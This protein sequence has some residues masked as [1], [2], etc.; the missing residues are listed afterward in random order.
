[1]YPVSAAYKTAIGQNVRDVRIT[2]TITLK[3]NSVIN[4]TD[5]DIVQGSLYITEQCVAGEDIEVGNVYASEMGLSLRMPLENPYSL[6]GARIIIN[7]GIN[8]ET[9][10]DKPPIWEYVPLGYFYV[11]EIQRKANNVNLT[12]LDGM[13]LFDIPV[14]DPGSSSPRNFVVYACEQAGVPLGTSVFEIDT[15]ANATLLFAAPDASKIKTCR[16]LLMW[17]CQIMGAFARMNRQGELEIVP[18]KARPSV[19]TISKAERFNSDVSDFA[20][21]ITKVSMQ[22]G[23]TVYSRG[24]DGMTMVLDENPFM[25]GLSESQINAVLDNLLAQITTAVYVPFNSNFIGDPALQPGDFVTLADT[26]VLGGGDV[27]SIITHSTWRY[28]GP[29]NLKAAGKHGLVRGVQNQQM[30]AVSSI[31]AIARAAQDL[32]L[33]ANQSTQLI[34]DA[35][36]G[37]VLIRQNPDETNEILIMDNPDPDQAVKIWR[38][39]MGG[40]GYSDNCVGADNPDREYE[41]AMTMDGAINANFIKTGQLDA[42]VVRIGPETTFAPGYD[43]TQ[44][45]PS[46]SATMGVDA[47]CL[48]LWH[49]DGSLNSHKGVAAIGD[50][51]FD[52]G[53]FGQAVKVTTPI[54]GDISTGKES[55]MS[56]SSMYSSS[57]SPDNLVDGSIVFGPGTAFASA[58]GA[59]F[60]QWHQIDLGGVFSINKVR[61]INNRQALNLPKDYTI[62]ISETGAFAGEQTVVATVTGNTTYSTWVEHTFNPTKGRYVRMTVSAV[63]SGT[64]YE[65]AEWQ[66][67]G[68]RLG[69]LKAPTTGLSAS[70]G[71]ISFR[72][73][74]LAESANGSVLIDLP[75]NVGNQGMLCGIADDGNLFIE[76]AKLQFSE[77]ETSQADFNTGTLSD[78]QA[79][80]AGN[81][82]LARDGQDFTY[83]ETS[84]ADF[85][86]GTLSD[87]VATSAGDLEIKKEEIDSYTKLLLHMD[88]SD[89]GT[90][91]TDECGKTVTRY[92]AVTK[93]G[94]KKF[95]TA[96]GY[97][98]GGESTRLEI[99]G[100]EAIGTGDFTVECWVNM[101]VG[102]K[103]NSVIE[104]NG[105]PSMRINTDNKVTAPMT[106]ALIHP[107]VLSTGTWYHLALVRYNGNTKLYVNGVGGTAIEDSRNYTATS[108][109]IGEVWDSTA[110]FNFNGYIDELRIS[111][112]IARWTSDFT[113]PSAPYGDGYKT[114]G[115]RIKEIDLSGANPAGGTKIEWSSTTP[116]G[117]SIKVE[118]ALS[119][120]G[121]NTYGPWL[122]AINGGSIPGIASDTDLSNAK[123][124]I[125]QTLSTTDASVTPKLHSLSLNIYAPYKSSGYRYKEYD[126]SAVGSVGSSKISWTEN[127][128]AN[129][130]LTVK[131]AVSTDGGSTYGSWQACTSGQ[132]IPG[133]T[134]GMDIS[135]ARLKVQEDLGTSDGTVTP[136]LQS[137]TIEVGSDVQRA[138]GPN[139][140]TLTAWDSISLAWKP[141]RLSLVVND[142]EACYIENPGLP[143]AFGSHVFI[144]TDR[145]GA[146]A[147]N[148]L[149]DE[150]RIDKVYREVNTR[151]GWHKTGVPFYTSEDM[152]QWPGYLRAETDGLKVYDSSDALRVLV[153]SWLKDAVRKYGIKII[154]GEIYST[155]IKTGTEGSKTYI[156]MEP[157]NKICTYKEINGVAV[158]QLELTDDYLRFWHNGDIIGWT[159]TSNEPTGLELALLGAAGTNLRLGGNKVFINGPSTFFGDLKMGSGTKYNIEQTENYGQRGLAVR[160]SPEQRYVDEGMGTLV[161]GE[162]RIDVD[163]IFLE[164]IEPH[165]EN[166]KW[167]IQLTPYADVDLFVSEIGDGY[168]IIKERKGGTSTG[169]E[170]T[171]SLS[172]IRKNYAGIRLMEVTN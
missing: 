133:L 37:H 8:V 157:P 59:A 94:V 66:I 80:S 25:T 152:K 18:I 90:I 96:S 136:Q 84:Q 56:A 98:D 111:K 166:S 31:V 87:V 91:F 165:K 27:A 150:L 79:T 88:G 122:E 109:K 154:D 28:R 15:F 127:T 20:V 160:E 71:T 53:C 22:V 162:C 105:F 24:T 112:G 10:P 144:G 45:D 46:A 155:L 33:A 70:Q 117:T 138:Y 120:D 48:G 3:D 124:K 137:L 168:F 125:R 102:N 11:T 130:T 97:F 86:S 68:T 116:A 92:G 159:T 146:N 69:V 115:T 167:F 131:A 81:L 145:N 132:A 7:F 44:I 113:P 21:K 41:I 121:G 51:S 119:T 52:T 61:W 54:S 126:I 32:A 163:P 108:T 107:T 142:S 110:G 5:E 169:A 9:D 65:L 100:L 114:A 158:R 13:L 75:D 83:T 161:N 135:N 148:T 47:D 140:S 26:S 164:C 12:A 101:S 74:N 55:G 60:P 153:G 57:F 123:L 82:E 72:A 143:T 38:W 141:D 30:K 89:N 43:P 50:E 156:A 4:I 67:Y 2:G 118:T 1:M 62:A 172:A 29:H 106:G 58:N 78:V 40:L 151:T 14:G 23:E 49:F 95:G 129:T 139:K 17:A 93:T 99:T 149:V 39:N 76:D 63:V 36:G 19:K 134:Q 16:D 73:K 128:P 42:G 104:S 147:I 64:Y 170:F 171:W 34:K 6:D 77:T 103:W 85:N 35:I